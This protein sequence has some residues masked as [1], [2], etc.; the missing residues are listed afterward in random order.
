MQHSYV[1]LVYWSGRALRTPLRSQRSDVGPEVKVDSVR[2]R[3][4]WGLRV[5][6]HVIHRTDMHDSR[7]EPMLDWNLELNPSTNWFY[8]NV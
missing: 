6:I 3:R 4:V 7:H 1:A 2:S 8:C 5:T